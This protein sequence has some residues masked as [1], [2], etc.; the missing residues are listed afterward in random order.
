MLTILGY[1][2]NNSLEQPQWQDYSDPRGMSTLITPRNNTADGFK[3]A[4]GPLGAAVSSSKAA[5][6]EPHSGATTD[7]SSNPAKKPPKSHIKPSLATRQHHQ[8]SNTRTTAMEHRDSRAR[9]FISSHPFPSQLGYIVDASHH[10]IARETT[11]NSA[12]VPLHTERAHL[13]L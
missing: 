8:G 7:T 9:P 13:V 11:S 1:C 12:A 4:S 10:F 2:A 3:Q 6:I 5:N